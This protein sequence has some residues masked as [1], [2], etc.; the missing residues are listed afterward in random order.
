MESGLLTDP[1]MIR[2]QAAY[3]SS[4]SD[5]RLHQAARCRFCYI[6][7]CDTSPHAPFNVL[8]APVLAPRLTYTRSRNLLKAVIHEPE[9]AWTH[10][11]LDSLHYPY[12]C[13]ETLRAELSA[14]GVPLHVFQVKAVARS[15]SRG[16]DQ[17]LH[18]RAHHGN[19][20]AHG[21]RVGSRLL[22]RRDR[23]A[24]SLLDLLNRDR[25]ANAQLGERVLVTG[26]AVLQ[27]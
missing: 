2:R 22:G 19:H 24:C 27:A 14:G 8:I 7:G 23:V 5:A 18:D 15:V 6:T 20:E 3:G 9:R 11:E 4:M 10:A 21:R 17:I 25:L 12:F 1:P 16:I 13:T 26:E